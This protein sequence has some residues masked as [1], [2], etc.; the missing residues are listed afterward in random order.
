MGLAAGLARADLVFQD[1]FDNLNAWTAV[2]PAGGTVETTNG[3]LHVTNGTGNSNPTSEG[4]YTNATVAPL[5]GGQVYFFGLTAVGSRTPANSNNSAGPVG[6]FSLSSASGLHW[7]DNTPAGWYIRNRSIG[8]TPQTEAM[9]IIDNDNPGAPFNVNEAI[10]YDLRIDYSLSSVTFY[11]KRSDSLTWKQLGTSFPLTPGASDYF[12]SLTAVS[13]FFA[14]FGEGA[15]WTLD[16][17]AVQTAGSDPLLTTPE[18]GSLSLLA[19][20]G[21]LLMRR[22]RANPAEQMA[23]HR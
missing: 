9:G 10:S 18:P 2:V 19:V 14:A 22:R 21:L 20:S 6:A 4:L 1:N 16:Q 5:A 12:V 13:D 7:F 15:D 3:L 23:R 17:I 8:G 11:D